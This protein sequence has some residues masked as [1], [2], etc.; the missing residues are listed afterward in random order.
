MFEFDKLRI[1]AVS[2]I[3]GTG[4]G[5]TATNQMLPLPSTNVHRLHF[6]LSV[7]QWRLARVWCKRKAGIFTLLIGTPGSCIIYRDN[8]GKNGMV[9]RYACA[10]LS[11]AFLAI[12]W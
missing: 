9:G 3:A 11:T 1:V 8:P 5:K 12:S 2:V 4:A 6:D 7:D 10:L